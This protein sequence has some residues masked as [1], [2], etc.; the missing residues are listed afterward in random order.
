MNI[1][2]K[3]LAILLIAGMV[4]SISGTLI[5]LNNTGR[6]G[7]TG[8]ATTDTSEGTV[9]YTISSNVQ[10]NFS[11]ADINFGS[12]YI[13]TEAGKSNCTMD[14]EGNTNLSSS[15]CIGLVSPGDTP[16]V[17]DNIGNKNASIN[18]SFDTAMATFL[19]HSVADESELWFDVND[20]ESS[21]NS[22]SYATY[23]AVPDTNEHE[24]CDEMR[25]TPGTANS[26]EINIKIAIDEEESGSTEMTIT[27]HAYEV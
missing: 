13:D 2:N 18:L 10:I 4:L 23:T 3:T 11:T 21:C 14:T 16:L 1:S 12:G 8:L 5:T 15:G 7:Y 19:P 24:I 17:L 20:H 27:A 26:M 22:S 6:S 9:N 25:F